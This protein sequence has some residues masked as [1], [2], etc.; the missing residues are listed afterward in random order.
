MN[1]YFIEVAKHLS[2][3][4]IEERDI[5]IQFYSEYYEEEGKTEQQLYDELGMPKK[6]AKV[7]VSNYLAENE[8]A[9]IFKEKPFKSIRWL[10][11]GILASPILL[12]AAIAL[13]A[14]LFALI[15]VIISLV[16]ALI[17]T[18][19]SIFIA[20]IAL[21]ASAFFV[22]N[23]SIFTYLFFTGSGLICLGISLLF[24]PLLVK[25]SKWCVSL[26]QRFLQFVVRKI[27][28]RKKVGVRYE[29]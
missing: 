17:V 13:V 8:D 29:N 3:L 15:I 12:P 19:G 26:V 18:I 6:F 5:L 28:D 20:G 10:L 27:G 14:V 22:I 25:F 11:L 21:I 9:V 23:S 24:V 4:P 16:F 1:D 2:M 7:L